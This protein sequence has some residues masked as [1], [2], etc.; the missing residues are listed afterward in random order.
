MANI[1]PESTLEIADTAG[2]KLQ[3]DPSGPTG[4]Y[5]LWTRV[6][7]FGAAAPA[8]SKKG[9]FAST[10]T[11]SS[12]PLPTAPS[13]KRGYSVKTRAPEASYWGHSTFRCSEVKPA[14]RT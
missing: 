7:D 10:S 2:A 3:V 14:P 5:D 1:T 4:V 13:S 9:I 6:V 8:F 11:V 12:G